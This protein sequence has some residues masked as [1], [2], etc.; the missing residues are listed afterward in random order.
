MKKILLIALALA[1]CLG[2]FSSCATKQE[3]TEA[4][5]NT[6][7]TE[8]TET[9]EAIVDSGE[10][11]DIE[12]YIAKDVDLFFTELDTVGSKKS[13]KGNYVEGASVKYARWVSTKFVDISEY[14][15]LKYELAAHNYLMSIAF[16]DAER[17]YISGVGT[18]SFLGTATVVAGYTLVPESA[19]YARF[20]DFQ[21]VVGGTNPIDSMFVKA[22]GNKTS[23]ETDRALEK[24]ADLKIACIGNSLTEG[25]YGS[26]QKGVAN[27]QLLNYPYYLAKSLGCQTINY[28]LCGKNAKNYYTDYY[29]K[30]DISDC[31]IILVM[32][33]TNKGLDGDYGKYYGKL[34]EAI[35]KDMK[36]DA[37]IVLI[38]P[39]SATTDTSKVNCGYSVNVT[40][41]YTFVT[42]YAKENNIKMIDAY[43][44]SPIQPDMETFYQPNDGLHMA[45][46]GYKAFA[47]FIAEELA[48]F[49]DGY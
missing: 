44:N 38:T 23:Y 10:N 5:E 25:D 32:L 3:S 28:G 1:C 11:G 37:I 20:T 15:A 42:S 2:S 26:G 27:K 47:E 13:A 31:D 4:T 48:K 14:Y 17:K 41:S 45:R 29:T 8:T 43:T 16:F 35:Q 49:L 18:E 34:I 46:E 33:G 9:V 7:I 36:K 22:Y 39:P 6:E 12:A 30:A 19:K 40:S 21:G 24:Y